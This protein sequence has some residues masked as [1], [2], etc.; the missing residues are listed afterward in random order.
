MP[1]DPALLGR[2]FDVE[3]TDT[4]K[5]FLRG[6]VLGESLVNIPI[7]VTPLLPGQVSGKESSRVSSSSPAVS[8][9]HSPQSG[10]LMDLRIM[11]VIFVA[12]LA[13]GLRLLLS[14]LPIWNFL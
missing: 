1:K 10:G 4:G 5:H 14:P 3:I 2:M 11:L 6:T 13:V 12:V 7:V 9:S 8:E